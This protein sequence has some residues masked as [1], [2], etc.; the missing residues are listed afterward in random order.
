MKALFDLMSAGGEEGKKV[1]ALFGDICTDVN[2]PVAMASK[3]WNIVHLSFTETHAK[4]GT[5][6]SM[7]VGQKIG[8]LIYP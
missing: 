2:E 5:A 3:N 6:D 7:E 1:M 4:F 8:Y